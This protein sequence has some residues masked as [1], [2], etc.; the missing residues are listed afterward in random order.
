[1][2]V[3]LIYSLKT[4]DNVKFL[5]AKLTDSALSSVWNISRMYLTFKP[6]AP[7]SLLLL[8]S[9]SGP[10]GP[11]TSSWL[12]LRLLL[13]LPAVLLQQPERSFQTSVRSYVAP[14]L[15]TLPPPAL[16]ALSIIS[17]LLT[18]APV[19]MRP[20]HSWSLRPRPVLPSSAPRCAPSLC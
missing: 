9:S 14:P 10:L 19:S 2:Y 4:G 1:M 6:W 7:V 16:S 18:M 12:V 13:L 15:S 8:S 5:W 11:C 20:G 17:K 3:C